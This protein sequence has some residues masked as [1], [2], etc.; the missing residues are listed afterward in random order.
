MATLNKKEVTLGRPQYHVRLKPGD[1]GK[2]VLLPGDPARSDRVAKYLDAPLLVSNNREYR[3][4]T[5][6]YKGTRVSVTSTGIGCPSASIAVE[7]LANIG[8]ECF[9]RIGSSAALREGIAIGDLLIS[10]GSMKN[11]GTSRYYVP[12]CFPA[13][14][15][16]DLTRVLVDTARR[17]QPQLGAAV[18]VGVCASDDSF[19]GETKEWIENLARLGIMNVEMESSAIF[20]VAQQRRLRAASICAVSGNLITGEVI[21]ETE[22]VGLAEG[23]DKEIKVVLEAIAAFEEFST[24]ARAGAS[25]A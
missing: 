8:V 17:M 7:E 9:I 10:T 24:S 4:Y 22:N 11:E 16:F 19:Y 2:Y 3:T 23:W 13:V 14:P 5:G 6:S 18:H 15:D 20:T 21:Y 25:F 1:V 12:D